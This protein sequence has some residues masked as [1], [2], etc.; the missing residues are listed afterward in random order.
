MLTGWLLPNYTE[1]EENYGFGV[2]SV[3][4]V[5]ISMWRPANYSSTGI[6]SDE[7]AVEAVVEDV[8]QVLM[9]K[10]A[11]LSSIEMS[12]LQE[13]EKKNEELLEA[14]RSCHVVT[15]HK[16]TDIGGG[17]VMALA[18][19]NKSQVRGCWTRSSIT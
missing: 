13:E 3:K 15:V 4:L 19:M 1:Y 12:E 7:R 14:G 2:T 16:A 10:A 8:H 18:G 9:A 11:L 6:Q 5:V 17:Q